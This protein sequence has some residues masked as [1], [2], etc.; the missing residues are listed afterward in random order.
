VTLPLISPVI[1]YNLVLSVIGL[2]RYFE[3]PYILSQGTG[4]P[5]NSTMFI[6]IHLYKNAFVFKEMG[7][8]SAL[9]WFLFVLA[10]GATLIVFFSARYWVYYAA[11]E[12]N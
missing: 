3:I 10:M 12:E 2:F 9:A 11:G 6:N 4:R 7:Y 8:G 5:G 1:F